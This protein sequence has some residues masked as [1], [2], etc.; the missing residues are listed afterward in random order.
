MNN[1]LEEAVKPIDFTVDI[2]WFAKVEVDCPITSM[3]SAG[4]VKLTIQ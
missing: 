1:N 3:G 4:F 2:S